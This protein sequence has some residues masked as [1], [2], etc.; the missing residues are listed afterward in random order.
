LQK[1]RQQE[2]QEKIK[3]NKNKKNKKGEMRCER[4]KLVAAV[5]FGIP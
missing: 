3:K 2:L 5:S 4:S 1:G